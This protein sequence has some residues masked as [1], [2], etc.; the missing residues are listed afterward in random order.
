MDRVLERCLVQI[1]CLAHRINLVIRRSF[2][3]DDALKFMFHLESQIKAVYGFYYVGG[4][5]RKNDMIG[6]LD[7]VKIHLSSIFEVRW[8]ASEKKA[9]DKLILYYQQIMAH[10]THVTTSDIFNGPTKDKAK[11][12][13]RTLNDKKISMILHFLA[14]ILETLEEASLEFQ[15]SYGLLIQ[16]AQNLKDLIQNLKIRAAKPG[17]NVLEALSK[18]KC[19]TD[20]CKTIE[21]YEGQNRVHFADMDRYEFGLETVRNSVYPKLTDVQFMMVSS[22][23]ENIRRYFPEGSL[24]MY[25]ILDPKTWPSPY[26]T[27]FGLEYIHELYDLVKPPGATKQEVSTQWK[28]LVKAIIADEEF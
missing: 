20:K 19:G 1:H 24:D 13:L 6:F 12:L 28:R 25:K 8:V 23:I 2:D 5:K 4:H 26:Q 17:S 7:G 3:K 9:V 21:K 16:Q 15:K 18:T 14:D 11:G 22:L 27:D 10:L